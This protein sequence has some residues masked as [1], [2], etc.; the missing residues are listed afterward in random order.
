ME[1]PWETLPAWCYN[2]RDFFLKERERIFLRSWQ[3]VGHVSEVAEPGSY[4]RFDLLDQTAIVMRG[5]DG[6]LHPAF[7]AN[8]RT[9]SSVRV[10]AKREF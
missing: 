10:R 1:G 4:L 3:L 9:R 7:H 8:A 5:D 6:E 2:D